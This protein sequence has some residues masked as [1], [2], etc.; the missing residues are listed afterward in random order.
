MANNFGHSVTVIDGATNATTTIQVGQ[1]PRGI[2]LNPVTNK[3]YTVNYGSQDVTVIDGATG[4]TTA[5]QTGKHPWAIAV[6]TEARQ[7]LCG[8]RRQR[9]CDDYPGGNQRRDHSGRGRDSFR[10]GSE[11]RDKKGYVLSYGNDTM[12]VIDGTTDSVSKTV[13]LGTHPQAI[14]ID[15]QSDQ[16]YV[17]NQRTASVTVIDGKTNL[18]VA[19]VDAGTI[20]YAFGI[21]PSAHLVYVANFSSNDVTVIRGVA[22]Q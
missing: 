15:A 12:A 11:S 17:A 19:K 3:V 4:A 13:I 6:D 22:T 2:A 8:Q 14:A 21:D 18:P 16:I 1:G 20:P 5:V 7:N 10:C 9:Q